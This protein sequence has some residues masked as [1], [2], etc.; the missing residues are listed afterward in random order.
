MGEEEEEEG[1]EAEVDRKEEDGI[2][3]GW[4]GTVL[5]ESE[6]GEAVEGGTAAVDGSGEAGTAGK[7]SAGADTTTGVEVNGAAAIGEEEE[8]AEVE[9]VDGV[10]GGD[11]DDCARAAVSALVD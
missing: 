8:A 9:A 1:R 5:M 11:S 3:M 10:A 4:L 7:M 6:K 2:G